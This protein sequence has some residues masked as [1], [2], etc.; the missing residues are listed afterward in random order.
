MSRM[1]GRVSA[2]GR[3]PKDREYETYGVLGLTKRIEI[4]NL[5]LPLY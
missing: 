4:Q 3:R 1:G 5:L 2:L